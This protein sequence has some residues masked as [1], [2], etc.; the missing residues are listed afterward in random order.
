AR[1][2]IRRENLV[3]YIMGCNI[4]TFIDT[5]VV[6]LL[7]RNPAATGVVIAQMI[8]IGVVSLLIL[9][10]AFRPYERLMLQITLW[11]TAT[12]LRLLLFF[13]LIFVIPLALMVI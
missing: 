9:L 2:Y 13:G 5:L 7:L 11:L 6:G 8:S 12:R 4:S 10:L 3:P 1:G